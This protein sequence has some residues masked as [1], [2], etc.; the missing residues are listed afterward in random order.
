MPI[1]NC[2]IDM[3]ASLDRSDYKAAKQKLPGLKVSIRQLI[4][5][6]TNF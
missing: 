5:L 1:A 2:I 3:Q 6:T 4:M